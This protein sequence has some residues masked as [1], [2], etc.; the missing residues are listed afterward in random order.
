ML[1]D[2]W[3]SSALELLKMVIQSIE[4]NK[5]FEEHLGLQAEHYTATTTVCGHC[6]VYINNNYI[7]ENGHVLCNLYIYYCFLFQIAHSGFLWI[8]SQKQSMMLASCSTI[9]FLDN[10][11]VFRCGYVKAVTNSTTRP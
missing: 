9:I 2:T 11:S 4:M 8:G 5:N 7:N 1:Q 10:I 3:P 6:G